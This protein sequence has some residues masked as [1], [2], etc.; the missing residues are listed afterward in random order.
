MSSRLTQSSS[1]ASL[2]A[3]NWFL[4]TQETWKTY[5]VVDLW[6]WHHLKPQL[7]PQARKIKDRTHTFC[8]YAIRS[9]VQFFSVPQPL[10][11]SGRERRPS[12]RVIAQS[13]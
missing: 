10:S 8:L 1:S 5:Q 2:A 12:D 11:R 7:E 9:H 3:L 13:M 6:H 4:L